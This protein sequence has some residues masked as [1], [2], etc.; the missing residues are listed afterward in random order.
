MKMC[1]QALLSTQ[2]PDKS[3][4]FR[5]LRTG[6]QKWARKDLRS[7]FDRLRKLPG[8][9]IADPS[10]TV[11]VVKKPVVISKESLEALA[12]EIEENFLRFNG[13][14]TNFKIFQK[15]ILTDLPNGRKAL[16]YYVSFTTDGN[17]A[18]QAILVTGT[19]KVRYRVTLSDHRINFDRNLELYY[20][21]MVS[22]DF[23]GT[24]KIGS[25]SLFLDGTNFVQWAVLVVLSG[26]VIGLI[27]RFRRRSDNLDDNA[28]ASISSVRP[29]STSQIPSSVAP[30]SQTPLSRVSGMDFGHQE[31]SAHPQT[32][33]RD[34]AEESA[35]PQSMIGVANNQGDGAALSESSD[36]VFTEK[37]LSA[38]PQSI[39][40]SQV[41]DETSAPPEMKKR[42][43]IFPNSKK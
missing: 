38:P 18:G 22:L 5:F 11:A 16:L 39:P 41:V 19:D 33:S 4:Q 26:V 21:Y 15:N 6:S 31:R 24:Q 34:A 3:F 30:Q 28:E 1:H 35:F 17:E 14:D 8:G 2:R 43:Q 7:L 9:L 25:S 27:A 29:S 37:D 42:W 40:L 23:K 10:L 32:A 13:R 36:V 12:K 20:P